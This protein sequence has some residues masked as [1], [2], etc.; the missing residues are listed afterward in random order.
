MR[1]ASHLSELASRL[2]DTP[3]WVETR[4]L[5][6]TGIGEVYGDG[7]HDDYVV[8]DPG[9]GPVFV[10]GRPASCVIH[11][12]V[13]RSGATEEVIAPIE[14]AAWLA[15]TFQGW[16]AGRAV[17]HELPDV[18]LLGG[19]ECASVRFIDRAE[20]DACEMEDELRAELVDATGHS[21]IAAQICGDGPVS[22]C[23]AGSETEQLWDVSIDTLAPHRRRGHAGACAVYMIRHMLGRGK[24]PVW[25]ALDTN[26]G[27][28]RLAAK[29][30]FVAMDA[31]MVFSPPERSSP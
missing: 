20:L 4:S 30:G 13:A 24:Q 23:Y 2:P 9:G 26:R 17:L 18:A 28:L 10:V 21:P 31:L 1:Q 14:D 19:I 25:A 3:R 16:T 11:E 27:S 8:R 6:L 15:S 5:L 12:A 29:L 7:D 22:F